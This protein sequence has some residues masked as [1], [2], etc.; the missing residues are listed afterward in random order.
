MP[1]AREEIFAKLDFQ[2]I[3]G[4]K[5]AVSAFRGKHVM[6]SAV[7]IKPAFPQAGASG[8][9]GLVAQDR[10]LC[11]GEAYQVG[12][13]KRTYTRARGFEM[14]TQAGF[15]QLEFAGEPG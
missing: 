4:S 7:P 15:G 5:V 6:E 12:G 1:V 9:N 10:G 13:G 14:V 2:I 8:N 11:I 3:K